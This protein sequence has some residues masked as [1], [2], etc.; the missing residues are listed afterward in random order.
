MQLDFRDALASDGNGP[1]PHNRTCS[2][3]EGVGRESR[4]IRHENRQVEDRQ[5]PLQFERICPGT[6]VSSAEYANCTVESRS[7][8]LCF[9]DLLARSLGELYG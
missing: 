9:D 3:Q 2:D 5:Q 1:P 8:I 4:A 7:T 6:K